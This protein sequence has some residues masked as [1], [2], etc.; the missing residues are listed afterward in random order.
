MQ[1][2]TYNGEILSDESMPLQ[3]A[4][5]LRTTY[6]DYFGNWPW[7]IGAVVCLTV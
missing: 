2:Q 6:K 1:H 7:Q 4:D 3:M 5:E